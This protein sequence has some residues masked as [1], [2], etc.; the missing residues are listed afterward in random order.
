MIAEDAPQD[1]EKAAASKKTVQ[2]TS[3]HST[4]AVDLKLSVSAP[5]TA[6][7]SSL[8]EADFISITWT[9]AETQASAQVFG[10]GQYRFLKGEDNNF[11]P[12]LFPN[13]AK[14]SREPYQGHFMKVT[15]EGKTL[16]CLKS[17]FHP[18]VQLFETALFFQRI[19]SDS[20][21]NFPTIITSGTA[22]GIWPSLDLGEYGEEGEDYLLLH[23]ELLD[24]E[25]CGWWV[26]HGYSDDVCTGGD[27]ATAR[28][29]T[30]EKVVCGVVRHYDLEKMTHP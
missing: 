18:K 19:V 1:A 8:P 29:A 30:Y 3:C 10:K 14:A 24:C 22:G 23:R 13:L 2:C 28:C 6:V 16:L 11:T 4:T 9:Q 17:E 26:F 12:L 21:P 7:V 5:S 15:V 27:G 25:N 20:K